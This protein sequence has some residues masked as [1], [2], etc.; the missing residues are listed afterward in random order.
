MK[1]RL[2]V[3]LVR[4]GFAPSRE[5]A[6]AVMAGC[7]MVINAG[8]PIGEANR[9]LADLIREAEEAGKLKSADSH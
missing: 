4:N 1:E 6:K 3:L 8:V 9:L 2:D 7:E 5:K